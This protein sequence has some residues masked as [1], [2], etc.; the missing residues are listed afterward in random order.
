MR[1]RVIQGGKGG[2]T[3]AGTHVPLITNWKGVVPEGKLC[4]DLIDFSD[5]LPTLAEVAGASL[6]ENVSIDGRSFLPQ[7]LGEEGNPRDWI[8]CHYDPQWGKRK[9]KRFARDKR[10]KLYHNGEL[11]DVQVDP[12]E[13]NPVKSDWGGR[14]AGEARQRL[15]AV[16]DSMTIS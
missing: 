13:E 15:Q 5:F 4:S 11:F 16:L 14:E 6:S 9:Q 2:T 12:L 8:F 1:S 10:W 7:L 3:D